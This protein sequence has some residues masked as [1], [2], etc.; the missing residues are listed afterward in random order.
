M[1]ALFELKTIQRRSRLTGAGHMEVGVGGGDIAVPHHALQVADIG[2]GLQQVG[3][4]TVA[5][6]VRGDPLP[7]SGR[8]GGAGHGL[9][10]A[11]CAVGGAGLLA[12][13]QPFRG[14]VLPDVIPQDRGCLRG[15]GQF[16]MLPGVHLHPDDP[17][18]R[19]DMSLFQGQQL[20]AAQPGAVGQQQQAFVLEIPGGPD[21]APDLLPTQH[22]GE[23]SDLAGA[24]DL[25]NL[26]VQVLD[27]FVP[28]FDGVDD[29]VPVGGRAGLF[30]L[31]LVQVFDHLLLQDFV[32]MAGRDVL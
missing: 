1:F 11:A 26:P 15:E 5:Q 27:L 2:A 22:F 20:G 29:L 32:G 30:V 10:Q 19:I 6:H 28:A 9:L 4:V 13:E 18:V 3:G 12:F 14:F 31:Q 21:H 8:A 23:L 25:E 17:T 16:A 7:Q 24:L